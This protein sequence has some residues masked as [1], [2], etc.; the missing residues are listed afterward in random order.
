MATASAVAPSEPTTDTLTLAGRPYIARRLTMAMDVER[1]RAAMRQESR[2][3]RERFPEASQNTEHDDF[4]TY[5]AL[6]ELRSF[7]GVIIRACYA[8]DGQEPPTLD[9]ITNAD[10][11]EVERCFRT[12]ADLNPILVG[13][14]PN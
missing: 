11:I 14:V 2:R 4:A 13:I 10:A 9:E 6:I 1:V 12:A 3:L 5:D 7:K 8:G